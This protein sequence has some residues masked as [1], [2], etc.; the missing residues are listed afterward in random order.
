VAHVAG[1]QQ[2][3]APVHTWPVPQSPQCCVCPHPTSRSPHD[4]PCTPQVVG[5]QQTLFWQ[6]PEQGPQSWVIPQPMLKVPQF[7]PSAAQ[8]VG[9]Q[10]PH[11]LAVPAPPHVSPAVLQPSPQSWVMPQPMLIV[12]QSFP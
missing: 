10:T 3:P 8:V 4:R 5:W 6:S 1:W 2:V 7:F 12:P 9:E 11:T